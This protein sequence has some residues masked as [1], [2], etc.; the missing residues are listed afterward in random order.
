VVIDAAG[1]MDDADLA[2]IDAEIERMLRR[3][4]SGRGNVVQ[5]L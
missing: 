3:G 1:S 2:V 4:T 5:H